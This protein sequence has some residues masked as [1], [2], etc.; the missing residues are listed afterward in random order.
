MLLI[1]VD[2]H[3]DKN[4]AV[5]DTKDAYLSA[6]INECIII[7]LKGKQVHIMHRVDQNIIF[8]NI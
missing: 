5:I 6:K 4:I 3:K 2:S 8:C 7:K 1:V